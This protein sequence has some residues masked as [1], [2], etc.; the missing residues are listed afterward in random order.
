MASNDSWDLK[1]SYWDTLINTLSMEGVYNKYFSA[2]SQRILI[3]TGL[4]VPHTGS[5]S[6]NSFGVSNTG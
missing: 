4:L 5:Y 6:T 2:C 3:D 1:S